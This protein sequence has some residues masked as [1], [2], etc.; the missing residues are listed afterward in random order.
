MATATARWAAERQATTM[1]TTTMAT[2]DNDDDNDDN[3]DDDN[4]NDDNDFAFIH[5]LNSYARNSS[6]TTTNANLGDW[7]V[8]YD[9]RPTAA[10]IAAGA[11]VAR[12]SPYRRRQGTG[13]VCQATTVGTLMG[14]V[15]ARARGRA[16]AGGRG[17][18]AAGGGAGRSCVRDALPAPAA[19]A[20]SSSCSLRKVEVKGMDPALRKTALEPEIDAI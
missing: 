15:R 17:T 16:R 8:W 20:P 14:G 7:D 11:A 10:N 9:G 4:D 6:N 3:D 12:S 2:G 13:E 1:T 5:N 19:P 18:R